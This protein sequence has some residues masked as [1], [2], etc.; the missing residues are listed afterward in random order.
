MR[1]ETIQHMIE[2][3]QETFEDLRV[4]ISLKTLEK[5][6][7]MVHKAMSGSARSYHTLEHV[8]TLWDSSDP[9]QS[10]AALFHDLIYYQ[11]D[12][13]FSAEIAPILF[14]YIQ[15]QEGE[16]M[17]TQEIPADDRLFRLTRDVFGVGAGQTLSLSSGLNEFLSALVMNKALGILSIKL[18]RNS[19]A[20]QMELNKFCFFN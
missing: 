8:F 13:G 1:L 11:V 19:F 15:E 6:A 17:L 7:M 12:K 16:V 20:S 10:L 5:L 4:H 9:L 18:D 14:P 2:I 3:F